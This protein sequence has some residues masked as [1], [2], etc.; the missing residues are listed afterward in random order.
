MHIYYQQ[1]YICN[2]ISLYL[3]Y[4]SPLCTRYIRGFGNT[5]I[6]YIYK[7][8]IYH[9]TIYLNIYLDINREMNTTNATYQ[10]HKYYNQ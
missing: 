9:K 2:S 10:Y 8:Y 4:K 6:I 5:Q 7:I 3:Q 1:S